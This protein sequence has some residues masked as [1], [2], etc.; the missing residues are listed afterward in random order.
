MNGMDEFQHAT[1]E[2]MKISPQSHVHAV[3][4]AICQEECGYRGE[5]ACWK[6]PSDWDGEKWIAVWPN[7]NCDE[8]GCIA[9]AWAALGALKVI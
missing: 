3:A 4:K 5:P 2:R 7:P 6:V 1:N 8:P 9:L